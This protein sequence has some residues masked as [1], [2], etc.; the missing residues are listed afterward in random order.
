MRWPFVKRPDPILGA[1]EELAASVAALSAG[2]VESTSS[3]GRPDELQELQELIAR[4][5]AAIAQLRHDHGEIRGAV[6]L[7]IEQED[8]REKRIKATVRRARKELRDQH[9]EDPALDAE[10]EQLQLVDDP[11]EAPWPDADDVA[12]GDDDEPSSVKGVSR[13]LLRRARGY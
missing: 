11:E 5:E 13:S 4:N 3:G 7:A 12:V 9:L 6:A 2:P 1:L 8:R 10:W